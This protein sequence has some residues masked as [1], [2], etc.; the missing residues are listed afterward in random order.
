MAQL[1][2]ICELNSILH[3]EEQAKE[4]LAN[5]K[6]VLT[7][8]L[9]QQE[10]RFYLEL[11]ERT[12]FEDAVSE[13]QN[14]LEKLISDHEIAAVTANQIAEFAATEQSKNISDRTESYAQE[15]FA[16]LQRVLKLSEKVQ[17]IEAHMNESDKICVNKVDAQLTVSQSELENLSYAFEK[18]IQSG[19][20]LLVKRHEKEARRKSCQSRLVTVQQDKDKA[21][22]DAAILKNDLK[23]H[24]ATV[25]RL[26]SA[27]E[28]KRATKIKNDG[29]H[30]ERLTAVQDSI[31]VVQEKEQVEVKTT[32]AIDVEIAALQQ[33]HQTLIGSCELVK[34]KL[35]AT[36]KAVE[37]VRCAAHEREQVVKELERNLRDTTSEID[38]T[39]TTQRSN[40]TH[41]FKDK[42]DALK[43]ELDQLKAQLQDTTTQF[44]TVQKELADN[45]L[46][47]RLSEL[48]AQL[49]SH[50]ES[51]RAAQSGMQELK[52]TRSAAAAKKDRI[53]TDQKTAEGTGVSLA[54]SRKALNDQALQSQEVPATPDVDKLQ[55][56]S[57]DQETQIDQLRKARAVLDKDAEQMSAALAEHKAKAVYLESQEAEYSKSEIKKYVEN[58]K[59]S[60][61]NKIREERIAEYRVE[62]N[63]LKKLLHDEDRSFQASLQKNTSQ[64]K[65]TA[66]WA[67]AIISSECF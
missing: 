48:Q 47:P 25:E 35:T 39:N 26:K 54:V 57:S 31:A 61:V 23:H 60:R 3:I 43:Q 5:K 63:G 14:V 66:V 53:E 12:R 65:T 55:Q 6:I 52:L 38:T 13:T 4:E 1:N 32:E 27:V 33:L 30:A 64:L 21:V 22:S 41:S 44:E 19:E 17:I 18:C 49:G 29:L 15:Q 28:E 37:E 46:H 58:Q 20:S 40:A 36:E 67:I 24:E 8:A 9:K 62:I 34:Q 59:Q 50:V 56:T 16:T 45:D 42:A 11:D 7:A 10:S 2:D 51:Q